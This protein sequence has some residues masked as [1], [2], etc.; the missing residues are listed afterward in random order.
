MI[1]SDA[2][3]GWLGN[4]AARAQTQ[5]AITALAAE[6][7]AIPAFAA[8]RQGLEPAARAGAEAVLALARAFIGDDEAVNGFIAAAVAAAAADPMCRPPFRASRNPVQDGLLLF[9]RPALAIQLAVM[10]G[11]SLALK[12]GSGDGRPAISFTGQLTLYRFLKGGGALLSIWEA[13]L[14]EPGFTAAAGGRCRLRERRPVS[15]GETLQL[16]GRRETFQVERSA[17]DLVYVAASTSLEASPVG[18]E[19]DP[20]TLGLL[21]TSSTDD[22]SSRTQMMLA[23]LRT[24]ERRDAAP[25]FARSA[26]TGPFHA[27]WQAMREFLALDAELALPHLCDMASSDP[28]EEVRA[29]AVETLAAFFP[30]RSERLEP[31]PPC[32]A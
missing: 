12:R 7:A 8:L 31:Y 2:L 32:L 26:R 13:P 9:S 11:D 6:V 14:I 1:V 30:G 23:L 25:L 17:G 29:A 3:A 27:R 10:S 24:M 21:A 16:D 22:A 28:H 4:A 5:A 15:D 20:R 19:Y 18:V